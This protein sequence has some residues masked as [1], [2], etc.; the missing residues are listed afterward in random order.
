MCTRKTVP[1]TSFLQNGVSH[2][3]ALGNSYTHRSTWEGRENP[4]RERY[5]TLLN[6][7]GRHRDPGSYPEVGSHSPPD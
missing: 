6:S 2:F 7:S 3:L 4:C 5:V 1:G